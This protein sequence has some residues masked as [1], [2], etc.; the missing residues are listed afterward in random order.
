[1]ARLVFT[2]LSGLRLE[3][4]NADGLGKAFI[5]PPTGGVVRLTHDQ[6]ER[7]EAQIIVLKNRGNITYT[8][9]TDDDPW[10]TICA[11]TGPLSLSGFP[12]IDGVTPVAND[13]VLVKNQADAKFNGIY[14]A[15][16][17]AWSRLTDLEGQSVLVPG[18]L[19]SVT[20]GTANGDTLFTLLSDSC[21]IG[22][23]DILFGAGAGAGV[24]NS[25]TAVVDAVALGHMEVASAA[26][27][28][29]GAGLLTPDVGISDN[30]LYLVF[31]NIGT[32]EAFRVFKFDYTFVDQPNLHIHW[33]KGGDTNQAGRAVRWIIDYKIFNGLNELGTGTTGTLDTGA[34][35]YA[36]SD[37]TGRTVYCSADMPLT[38]V[39]AGDYMTVKITTIAPGDGY[40][41]L[42]DPSL[43]TLDLEFRR[44]INKEVPPP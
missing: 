34:L 21:I 44:Y 10:R 12:L 43:V 11:S 24:V 16:A 7:A 27:L 29:H 3:V 42:V 39:G 33:T 41:Q 1:M 4:A 35:V 14:V 20:K 30:L 26:T 25:I 15:S 5:I 13:L 9:Q 23:D 6:Y 31:N 32:D 17:G 19:V 37:T 22:T 36:A 8:L 28:V 38:G 18:M 2:N 40:T